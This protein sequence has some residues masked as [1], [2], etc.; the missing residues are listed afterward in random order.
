MYS[1]LNG[2][3]GIG[4]GIISHIISVFTWGGGWVGGGGWDWAE[5]RETCQDELPLLE[6]VSSE[7]KQVRYVTA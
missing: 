2:F 4:R 5:V 3:L 6:L 1:G 7:Y